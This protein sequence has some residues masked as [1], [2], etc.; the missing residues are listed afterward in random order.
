M[1]E[2][3]ERR[4]SWS[5]FWMKKHVSFVFMPLLD[6]LHVHSFFIVVSPARFWYLFLERDVAA[7]VL[8]TNLFGNSLPLETGSLR[9]SSREL[10]KWQEEKK[11]E[12]EETTWLHL[13]KGWR[14]CLFPSFMILFLRHRSSSPRLLLRLP[15][16]LLSSLICFLPLLLPSTTKRAASSIY[17]S[18]S[19]FL[20]LLL[21][22]SLFE[23]QSFEF[24]LDSV[25]V[26]RRRRRWRAKRERS[27]FPFSLLLKQRCKG[28][29]A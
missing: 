16:P 5:W 27:P 20:L 11:V 22:V 3:D 29:E 17:Q 1:N 19:D 2:K 26:Q 18:W 24:V 13:K 21:L 28:S 23:D 8:V 9:I 14:C 4:Q 10:A 12:G 7:P 15:S 25:S 6:S